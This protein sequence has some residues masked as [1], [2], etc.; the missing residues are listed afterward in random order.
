MTTRLAGGVLTG[1]FRE[2]ADDL[3]IAVVAEVMGGLEPA[4]DYVLELLQ[5]GRHVVTANK[6]LVARRGAELFAA[7][8]SQAG[9]AAVRGERLR[10]DPRDQ[11]AARVA[12]RDE[13]PSRARHRQRYD[14]LRA[15]RDGSREHLRRGA[16]RGAE[17]RLRRGGPHRRR[18][19][20]RRGREDGDSRDRRLQVA[21]RARR[22]RLLRHHDDRPARPRRRTRARHGDPAGR[23][24]RGSSTGTSTCT[25]SRRS[26]TSSIRSR[27]STARSTP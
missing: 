11:G 23:Q 24:P 8:S 12:G 27:R 18:V 20:R 2:I 6:Q 15:H 25:S 7:A 14:E 16:R 26:S 22:R 5:R 21:R 17:A 3:S 13:R 4:G 9:P 10:G 19:G 1:D